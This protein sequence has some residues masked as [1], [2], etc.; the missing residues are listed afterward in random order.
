GGAATVSLVAEV[1]GQMVGHILFSPLT[2]QGAD[3]LKA[4]GLG[5]MAVIPEHQR[6]GIG[7]ILIK[8]G[9]E[10]CRRAGIQAVVVLGHPEYYPRFGFR[11]ASSWGLR[12]E[13]DAPDEAF[14]ALELIPNVLSGR[15]GV[16]N[17]HA[18]FKGF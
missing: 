16:V 5:P 8:Q 17:Y 6:R 10:D 11:R 14:M 15:S 2:V 12:C 7:S 1:K 13:F 9:L 3:D 18:A 4:V